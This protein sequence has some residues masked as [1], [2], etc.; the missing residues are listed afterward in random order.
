MSFGVALGLQRVNQRGAVLVFL[1][2]GIKKATGLVSALSGHHSTISR[3]E[4]KGHLHPSVSNRN[5]DRL[6]DPLVFDV[7]VFVLAPPSNGC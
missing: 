7:R 3:M 1:Q 4:I 5:P 6:K 2:T